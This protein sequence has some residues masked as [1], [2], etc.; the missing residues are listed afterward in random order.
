MWE[1]VE[2]ADMYRVGILPSENI[3]G[4][5]KY[6]VNETEA[7][8]YG[9]D[10]VQTYKIFVI[11]ENTNFGLVSK[12]TYSTALALNPMATTNGRGPSV[13]R[14]NTQLKGS[15]NDQPTVFGKIFS[16][17]YLAHRGYFEAWRCR[18][19]EKKLNP[20]TVV[21]PG[22][23]PEC[24]SPGVFFSKIQQIAK[25]NIPGPNSTAVTTA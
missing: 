12:K 22:L 8:L 25:C 3:I 11:A 18:F 2:K 6:N 16:K 9:L 1:R 7:R 17:I 13:G 14:P 21:T 10:P 4:T 5:G 24:N 19:I 20:P 23:L 15:T